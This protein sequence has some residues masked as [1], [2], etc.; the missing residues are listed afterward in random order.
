VTVEARL[1]DL[2]AGLSR[3]ADLGF[4]LQAGEALRSCALATRLARSLDL[5]EDDARSAFYTAL[6]HHVGCTGY[7]HETARVFGDELV[8]NLA[9][10]RTD[11][12]DPRD[13]LATFLPTL[14]RGR[15]PLER[16][17]LALTTLTKGSRF[18][19]AYTTA[20]CEVGRD[21]AR[22]LGL[23]EAVQRGVYHVYEEWRGGGLP[24][25]L[26]GDD[27]PAGSRLAR[28]TGIAV[29][30]DTVGGAE[31]AA[32]AVRRR[33]GG[34][35]DPGMAGRFA[36]HA[37][38]LLGELNASDPRAM[39]LDAEPPPV[40]TVPDRDLAGVAAT[41]GD[42]ADLKTP[43]THGHS[44]GVAALARGAGERL[45]LPPGGVA[46]LE[47]AGL[48][49]DLG[50][51]A[52]SD[53]VWEKPARLSAHEREQVRLHAYHS[54][55]IL[56]GS[57][58]LAALAPLAGMH[59]ERL[60]GG[61]YHRACTGAD[62]PLPARLL[63]AADAYQAMTQPRPHRPALAPEDA[64]RELLAG[65]RSGALDPD[66]VG[67]VLAAAG[68]D[69]VVPRR[70]LPAGLS[71]REVEVLG[72]VAEGCSNA[73]IAQRLVISRRTAE[74]HVQ[75]IYAKIGVSSRAAAALF[76]MEHQLLR[77]R[78]R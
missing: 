12:A 4:G 25:G 36:D 37:E 38:A 59:H 70:E 73:Q 49:H 33:G 40:V 18:G 6:L 28:L 17:R 13:L 58:R 24:A 29:L 60:D 20:A 78:D 48:L 9:A 68:H 77:R 43:S 16:A 65:A 41:F 5:P 69:A 14:T 35:L 31:L 45:R 56:A 66:A 27:I 71:A 76:G 54:E 30:F 61:G 63:A 32:D 62:L 39:V 64:E 51:V 3:L 57:Q 15:P 8:L 26:A 44:R 75:H 72:L 67:A 74:H 50:R 42:L 47:V 23:P 2:L 21:A 19:K 10:G 34:M 52:V 11:S 46:D 53:V 1:A 7:A 55:R 22:R